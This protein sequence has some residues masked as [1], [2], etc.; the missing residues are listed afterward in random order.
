MDSCLYIWQ[1]LECSGRGKC[2]V[3]VTFI[4][5]RL[6]IA[7]GGGKLTLTVHE[8]DPEFRVN[9]ISNRTLSEGCIIII[10]IIIIADSSPW[11]S[12]SSSLFHAISV[13]FALATMRCCG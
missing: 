6:G 13:D 10:I 11:R 9:P 12:L 3:Y 4:V 2:F 7:K 1:R 5:L 8:L